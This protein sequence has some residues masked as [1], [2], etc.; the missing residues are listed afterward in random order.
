MWHLHDSIVW[1]PHRVLYPSY[2]R[3]YAELARGTRETDQ[4]S[5]TLTSSIHALNS[6]VSKQPEMRSEL[7]RRGV[8]RTCTFHHSSVGPLNSAAPR[9]ELTSSYENIIKLT[10]YSFYFSLSSPYLLRYNIKQTP[11][12]GISSLTCVFLWW[13]SNDSRTS[14]FVRFS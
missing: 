10:P 4:L 6:R 8:S 12:G 7:I 5:W 1:N 3:R 2:P 14:Y 13:F 9:R 11:M